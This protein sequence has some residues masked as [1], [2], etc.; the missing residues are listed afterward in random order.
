MPQ[1]KRKTSKN[2]LYF[3]MLK[4][5]QRQTN[6]HFKILKC[7]KYKVDLRHLRHVKKKGRV[8]HHPTSVDIARAERAW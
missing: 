1:C 5:F 7:P 8:R 4:I 3:K 6:L 2:N